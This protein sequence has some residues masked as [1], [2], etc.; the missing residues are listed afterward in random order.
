MIRT[1]ILLL[2]IYVALFWSVA[3]AGNGKKRSTPR[4]FLGKFM[5]FPLIIFISHLI[6][7]A[8]YPEIYP[9]FDVILQYASLM[10]FPIYYIYFRLLTVDD[11][12]SIKAHGRFLIIPMLI[13]TIYV[14]GVLLTPK[15]EFRTW[16]FDQ[17][18]Y[19]DSLHIKFLDVMR[20]IIRI[21]YLIQVVVSVT[22]NYLLIRKYSSKAEQY[23]S[24]LQDGKYNNAIMLNRSIIV[25]GLT[26]FIF[27][28]VGRQYLMGQNVMIDVGWI[29]FSVMLFIIGYMG[30]KQKPINPTYDLETDMQVQDDEIKQL[31]D[32]QKAILHKLTMEFEQKK[33]YLNS[34]L[35]ILDVVQAVGT[36]RSYISAIINQQYHQ[37]F[38]AFVN[39]YRMVE[40][41]R[42]L[43]DHQDFSNE[44][45]AESCGF[46][47]VI[48]LKRA[49]SAKTGM[50]I[51]EW[52]KQLK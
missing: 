33:I 10:A 5:L 31:S 23:Y 18:A 30:L 40:L 9:W 19:S 11:K 49:V 14:V 3:L 8:P 29:V 41:D 2:P 45:L 1:I 6:Y 48:S 7:F 43:H 37:N 52:K 38:C 15:V 42:I 46:G 44:M 25:L 27:I 39:S 35:N 17:N 24:D 47:S 26:A 28:L 50:S 21:I 12:F 4:K 16:L 22:G 36:N 20:Y 34:Q 51:N 32:T 13:G